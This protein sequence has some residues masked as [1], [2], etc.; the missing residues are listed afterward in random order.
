MYF[1]TLAQKVKHIIV[2][3]AEAWEN[4]QPL[5]ERLSGFI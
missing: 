5:E 4:R 1:S 3:S 2:N